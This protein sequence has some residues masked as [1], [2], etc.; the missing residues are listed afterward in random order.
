MRKKKKVLPSKTLIPSDPV[1]MYLRE[2]AKYPILSKTEEQ[3]LGRLFYKTRDPKIGQALARANLRFVVKIA[4]EYTR[5]GS[6]LIDLIQEGNIG[7]LHAVK[8][9]NPYKGVRLITYA[10][11]WIRGYIQEYLMRQYS[12]V[13]IGTTAE[14]RRL[15]YQLKRQQEELAQLP[16]QKSTKL[17][18]Q[19]SG[20]KAKEVEAMDQRLKKRDLSLDM[21]A[22]ENSSERLVDLQADKE[23][24]SLEERLNLFQ[25]KNL[26]HESLKKIRPSLNE[27]ERFILDERLLKQKPLTLQEIGQKYFVTREAIRQ[28]ENRLIKKIKLSVMKQMKPKNN[29]RPS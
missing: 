28:V 20:V 11:W 18:T 9:F 13:R 3:R 15:F 12:L 10:V 24:S 25:E 23:T 16:Y 6:R 1:Q 29:L 2:I 19:F 27:K 8:E 26:V 7:L 21:P 5:F 14:Q 4:I 17:I 22:S